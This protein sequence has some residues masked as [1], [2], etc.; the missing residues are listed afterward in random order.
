MVISDWNHI[1]CFQVLALF[2][3]CNNFCCLDDGFLIVRITTF[4]SKV[5]QLFK[6]CFTKKMI[7]NRIVHLIQSKFFCDVFLTFEFPCPIIWIPIVYNAFPAWWVMSSMG[8]RNALNSKPKVNVST[9]FYRFLCHNIGSEFKNIY[10]P[11]YLIH[12]FLS[13]VWSTSTKAIISD[14]I[15]KI[16][17]L[18][19]DRALT[20]QSPLQPTAIEWL[21][22][23]NL[24]KLSWNNHIWQDSSKCW[25]AT[26]LGA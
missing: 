18:R 19:R 7:I 12:V 24:H 22:N 25:I 4:S 11:L 1:K 5:N 23:T 6:T 15:R 20:S 26:S 3:P 9:L 2:W 10:E 14:V 8:V 13:R 21:F 17:L 16:L